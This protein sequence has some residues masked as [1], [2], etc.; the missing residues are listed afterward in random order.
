MEASTTSRRPRRRTAKAQR[1]Y[2]WDDFIALDDEDRRELIDGQLIEV[3]VP[4][5]PHEYIVGLL[6]HFLN[7]WALKHGGVVLG[8]GYKIRVSSERGVMPDIQYFGPGNP[9]SKSMKVSD[10][11]K[12]DLAV[13]IISPS[14]GKYDR[15]IKLRWYASIGVS[16][17]W[18]VDSELRLLQRFILQNGRYLVTDSVSESQVFKPAS[19]KGLAIPLAKLWLPPETP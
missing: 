13:E 4:G 5:Y 14:S 3:E 7:A 16:E 8:S 18:L 2:T 10:A 19:F 11:Y 6:I 15:D 9:R 1:T 12:P 17:Y